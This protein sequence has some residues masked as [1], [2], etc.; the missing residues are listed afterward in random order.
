MQLVIC[1]HTSYTVCISL[2]T[3]TAQ[4][5]VQAY[6]R[7][8]YS[9]FGGSEKSLSD[10]G[11]E[12]K[13]QLFHKVTKQLGVEYKIYTT[14]YGPH[15]N[16]KIEGFHKYL[17][18]CM[19]KHIVNNMEWDEFT[20]LATAAYNFVPNI[21]AIEVS[22][23][24]MLGRDPYI[25]LYQLMLQT[26]R[27]LGTDEGL[28]DLE[29]LQNLLQMATTQIQYAAIGRNQNFKLVKP[30]EFMVGDLVLVRNY[31]SKDFQEKYQ[32][33]FQIKNLLGKNQLEV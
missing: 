30:H 7:H 33:S 26:R 29:A 20:D 10:N 19:A 24:V 1:M 5:V 12:L 22:F 3:R 15:C 14:P 32:D 6:M 16:G 13:N 4:E 2:M 31:T 25:T 23:Y 11:T 17:K 28:P 27:Y 21:T 9:K 8:V 18:S